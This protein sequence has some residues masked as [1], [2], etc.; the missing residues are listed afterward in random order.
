MMQTLKDEGAD[1]IKKRDQCFEEYQKINST[2]ADVSWKIKKNEMAIQ[3]LEDTI[4]ALKTEKTETIDAI[5]ATD[6]Q[7]TDMKA[8]RKTENGE[9]LKAKK[10]DQDAIALLAQAR[11][12]LAAYYKNNSIELGPVQGVS[13]SQQGPEFQVSED[14]APDAT[15]SGKGKRKSESKGII[16]LLT[17]IMEDLRDEIRNGMKFEEIAQLEF[18]KQLA[19]A[20]K[21]KAEL[22][23]K[24][25]NLDS[26]IAKRTED[27]N[28]ENTDMT[29]N[30][31]DLKD[32]EDYRTQIQ[33]DCDWIIGA[34]ETRAKKRAAEMDGLV[35]AKEF[36]AGYQP[37]EAALLEQP[38]RQEFND[39]ALADIAFHSLAR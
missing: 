30:K 23:A 5:T 39:G 37:A 28:D 38:A 19:A 10:E 3:K 21:L 12:V 17:M 16:S 24:K 20:E 2:V 8:Q 26:M 25:V 33:P 4:D 15:F 7:I 14:Q 34:F 9:F 11:D 13:L 1:D 35:A 32:E 6:T 36:L 22:E 29:N 27:K 31:K 18:E